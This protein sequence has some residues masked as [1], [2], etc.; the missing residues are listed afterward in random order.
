M[1]AEGQ[2]AVPLLAD[3][4][5]LLAAE[6][7]PEHGAALQVPVDSKAPAAAGQDLARVMGVLS[8]ATP[9]DVTF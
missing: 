6:G 4:L 2:L 1:A 9:A 8:E 5:Q 3:V 7:V